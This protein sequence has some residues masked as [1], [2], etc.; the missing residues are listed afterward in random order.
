MKSNRDEGVEGSIYSG[1]KDRRDE[2]PDKDLARAYNEAWWDQGTSV[3]GNLR[4]SL[5]IEPENG[6]LP[7]L[8]E[9]AQ[10][11]AAIRAQRSARPPEGPEDRG[12]QERCI[13][14]VNVGPPIL[15]TVYNNNFQIVQTPGT[16]AILSE[17][18]HDVRLIPTDNS[19]HLPSNIRLFRGDS[20]AHWEGDTLV[21]DTTNYND[22]IH[23][24]SSDRNLHVVERFTR[25][26]EDKLLYQFRVE[27][28][29]AYTAPWAGEY[30]MRPTNGLIYEYGCQEGNRGMEYSLRAARKEEEEKEGGK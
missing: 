7:P 16:V 26:D 28:P 5:V 20:R 4:T 19:A 14:G 27:D 18:V 13:V 23:I 17:M 25:V 15:P 1:N 3:Q 21:V 9:A 30:T 6:R 29:T 22:T 24:R 10:K 11:D 2:D 12:I 8:T